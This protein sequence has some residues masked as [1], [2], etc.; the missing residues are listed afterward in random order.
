MISPWI[1]VG[2]FDAVSAALANDFVN[3]AWVLEETFFPEDEMSEP[4]A[5]AYPA[6]SGPA[7]RRRTG[8]QRARVGRAAAQG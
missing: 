2:Y 3:S 6:V 8:I 1:D 7:S 4:A 5:V